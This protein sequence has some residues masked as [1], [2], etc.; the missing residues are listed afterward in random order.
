MINPE[1]IRTASEEQRLDEIH[2][3]ETRAPSDEQC[4]GDLAQESTRSP[5]AVNQEVF[6]LILV[7]SLWIYYF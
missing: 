4:L 6:K 7:Y 2:A 3:K 1:E 5:T